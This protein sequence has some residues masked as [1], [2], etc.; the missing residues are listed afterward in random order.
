MKRAALYA[1]VST[2][3]QKEE[4]TIKSQLFELRQQIA[5]D[6]NT[7]GVGPG[8]SPFSLAD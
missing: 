3:L 8:G 4:G 7:L 2:D 6:G 5:R 1:R